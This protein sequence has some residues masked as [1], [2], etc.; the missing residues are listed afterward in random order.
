MHA[1]THTLN[2]AQHHKHTHTS[3]TDDLGDTGYKLNDPFIDDSDLQPQM[4]SAL[5]YNPRLT[6]TSLW[7]YHWPWPAEYLFIIMFVILF[8]ALSYCDRTLFLCTQ[9]QSSLIH[10]LS[11]TLGLTVHH[12]YH[13]SNPLM[14]TRGTHVAQ[15]RIYKRRT[16]AFSF[17]E[18]KSRLWK[19]MIIV[20]TMIVVTLVVVMVVVVMWDRWQRST[21]HIANTC[22]MNSC[23]PYLHSS[24]TQKKQSKEDKKRE[25][26]IS[27]VPS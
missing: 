6:P 25:Q 14:H 7:P 18:D 9:L 21:T 12:L 10:S 4:R 22:N 5:T 11:F 1:C 26:I 8:S 19:C 16:K 27:W 2:S 24:T 23:A 13:L 17:K 20:A 3:C 15:T